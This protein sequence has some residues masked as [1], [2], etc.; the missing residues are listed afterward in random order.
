MY[1]LGNIWVQFEY[2]WTFDFFIFH[3]FFFGNVSFIISNFI[4]DHLPIEVR[5][6]EL[7]LVPALVLISSEE[8]AGEE[9]RDSTEKV[10]LRFAPETLKEIV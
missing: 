1:F 4:T 2:F 7:Q 3:M 6:A 10:V 9:M 5:Q 8:H